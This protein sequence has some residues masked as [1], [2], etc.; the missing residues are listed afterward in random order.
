M[1]QKTAFSPKSPHFH[2]IVTGTEQDCVADPRSTRK[3]AGAY[4][5]ALFVRR[6]RR[7]IGDEF[8]ETRILPER[9]EHRIESEQRGSERHA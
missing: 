4:L 7:K 8:L 5:S 9:I 3:F 1:L 6:F 2:R